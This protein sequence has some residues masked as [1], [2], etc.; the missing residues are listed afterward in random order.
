MEIPCDCDEAIN[1]MKVKPMSYGD[2][3]SG[4]SL[5]LNGEIKSDY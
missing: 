4:F 2:S 5:A 3:N 1:T